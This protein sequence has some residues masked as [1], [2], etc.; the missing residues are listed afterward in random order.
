M[1]MANT[2]LEA[3]KLCLWDFNRATI[4]AIELEAS[5]VAPGEREKLDFLAERI[6]RDAAR[7]PRDRAVESDGLNLANSRRSRRDSW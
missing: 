4:D 5:D 2:F 1:A 3:V 7:C 6:R